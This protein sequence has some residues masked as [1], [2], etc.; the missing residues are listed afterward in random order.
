MLATCKHIFGVRISVTRLG[1]IS[2]F[3]L[4]FTW[5]IFTQTNSFN[6]WFVWRFQKWF[7]VDV[8]GFQ[9]NLWGRYF[10]IFAHFFPKI[11]QN[12]IQFSGHT[13]ETAVQLQLSTFCIWFRLLWKSS[14]LPSIFLRFQSIQ[15]VNRIQKLNGKKHYSPLLI[16][17]IIMTC[18]HDKIWFLNNVFHLTYLATTTI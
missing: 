1:K 9:I 12:F 13:G 18:R 4:C 14:K 7:N 11:R 2:S 5:P 6:P 17:N 8:L 3:R 16:C 10:G 15:S